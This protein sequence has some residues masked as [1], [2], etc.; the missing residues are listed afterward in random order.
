MYT[1]RVATI[2]PKKPGLAHMFP[3]IYFSHILYFGEKEKS[4]NVHE[5]I[6]KIRCENS[7]HHLMNTA[8][9]IQ[10]DSGISTSSRAAT[11]AYHCAVRIG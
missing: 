4:R 8:R 11:D 9:T 10:L 7:K 5:H 6:S 2:T 1:R 3:K